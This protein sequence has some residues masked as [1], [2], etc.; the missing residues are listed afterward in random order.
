MKDLNEEFI[1]NLNAVFQANKGDNQVSFDVLEIEKLKKIAE[2]NSEI[3][4]NP[5]KQ[6]AV[7]FDDHTSDEEAIFTEEIPEDEE[8]IVT[9]T[10]SEVEENKVITRL[11]MPSR[12]LK[13]KI[14]H[15]LLM[16]LERLQVN[17]KL[18]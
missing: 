2:N 10:I 4:K 16:E 15:E 1:A 9:E 17:F 13:I 7:L 6:E 5:Q 3:L 11:S 14:S 18:N 8:P 12:K